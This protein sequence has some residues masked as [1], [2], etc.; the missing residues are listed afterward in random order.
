[1]TGERTAPIPLEV[2]GDRGAG[3]TYSPQG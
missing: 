2:T 1:V 3:R